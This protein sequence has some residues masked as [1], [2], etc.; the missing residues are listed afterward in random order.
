ML[1]KPGTMTTVTRTFAFAAALCLLGAAQSH[2]WDA[3]YLGRF[4]I[5]DATPAPWVKSSDELDPAEPKDLI[6]KTIEIN[7]DSIAG[8][9]SF[10]CQKPQYQVIEGGPEMLFQ[11]SFEN[12]RAEDPSQ[13]T[14]K[15]AAEAGFTADTHF[16]TVITGCEFD[17]DMSFGADDN[18]ARFALNNTIYTIRRE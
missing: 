12:M 16:R 11:G 7:A 6:G 17:V 3:F 18:L 10:P 13:D 5:V 8:P 2:A 1:W 9:G 4:K 15:L 14:L